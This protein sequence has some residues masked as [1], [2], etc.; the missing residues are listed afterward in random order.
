[1]NIILLSGGS[2][3]RL[4]P[5]SN[6]IRSKQF[7]KLLK[8]DA[9]KPESMVQRVYRQIKEASIESEIIVAA[10]K[11]QID[12]IR[13]QLENS[14][15][16]VP[17]PER[18][19]TFPA[20]ALS[21]AYLAFKKNMNMNE[22]V[23]VLPID[24]YAEL[25]YFRT[26]VKM[27]QMII[28]GKSNIALMGIKP[29]YPSVNYG[30]II[31]GK[32]LYSVERFQEKPSEE[33]AEILVKENAL[34]N[35]GVFA[36]KLGYIMDIVNKYIDFDS[37]EEIIKK[38]YALPKI[39][40]DYEVV[41]KEK[42]ISVIEYQGIWKDLGTWNTLTEA[43]DCNTS[44]NVILDDKCINTHVINELDIPTTVLG[45]DNMVVVAC[46]DGIL[47]SEK[48]KSSALK[49]YVEKIHQRPMYEERRWGEYKVLDYASYEDGTS[50][51]TKSLFI[52][53]GKSI[54]YQSHAA[55]DEIWTIVD[56]AGELVIDGHVKSVKKGDVA[57]ITKGQKH[58]VN[59][60]T[61]L[62]MIEVQIGVELTESDIEK[63]RWEWEETLKCQV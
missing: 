55:R 14:V 32:E 21:C 7:L 53:K 1:M 38:Y 49:S 22:V 6:E 47:V 54:S 40:F 39:S 37:Y 60:K 5:L 23:L 48:N 36:F 15:D 28:D 63:Y 11:Y 58:A 34:W 30:Y 56:G 24:P 26:L 61:D 3:K 20:I 19:D 50:S 35:G 25:D 2:G 33:Y 8:D 43:M 27:E 44:G 57:Y 10:G 13:S 51:L 17:E 46:P 29:T 12:S 16:I 62:R 45:A 18:R 41:E 42:S 52:K 59:A 4:W 31:P 9:G